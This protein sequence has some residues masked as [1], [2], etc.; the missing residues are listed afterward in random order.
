MK[1]YKIMAETVLYDEYKDILSINPKYNQ[2]IN[3]SATT[4]KGRVVMRVVVNLCANSIINYDVIKNRKFHQFT[5]GVMKNKDGK[6][7]YFP[8]NANQIAYY[9][10]VSVSGATMSSLAHN[11]LL[12]KRGKFDG[13]YQYE[14]P[15]DFFETNDLSIKFEKSVSTDF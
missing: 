11:G 3:C 6:F 7:D 15:E 12:I 1:G 2:L 9:G 14:L 8:F 10:G 4:P 13:V 5:F